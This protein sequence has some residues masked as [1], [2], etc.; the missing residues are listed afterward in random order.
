MLPVMSKNDRLPQ[1]ER[2]YRQLMLEL[3]GRDHPPEWWEGYRRQRRQRLR[4]LI[5]RLVSGAYFP[6]VP[7]SPL[8]FSDWE[9]E[10]FEEAFIQCYWL[11]ALGLPLSG[12]LEGDLP[13]FLCR[14]GQ[15]GWLISLNAERWAQNQAERP[16]G[17]P[18]WAQGTWD[19]WR[20]REWGP[21]PALVQGM[22]HGAFR[23]G[24]GKGKG[25][26]QVPMIWS[27]THAW[28]IVDKLSE[29]WKLESR[30]GSLLNAQGL[31]CPN[32]LEMRIMEWPAPVHSLDLG[33]Y[34]LSFVKD[35]GARRQGN[36]SGGRWKPELQPRV[37]S[38][39]IADIR[40]WPYRRWLAL[41]A[42]SL[43]QVLGPRIAY[44]QS[45]YARRVPGSWTKIQEAIQ[46][47]ILQW[48]RAKYRG[49]APL[50]RKKA[51]LLM[52]SLNLEEVF[53]RSTRRAYRDLARQG[54]LGKYETEWT[55]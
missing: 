12:R 41:D 45:Q 38:Q 2:V 11:K 33:D 22:A 52:G 50:S 35:F 40:H 10:E 6:S 25:K 20:S 24:K 30:L 3:P 17:H 1:E 4:L 9:K 19:R 21:P 7:I 14:L 32:P 49:Q 18:P 55:E 8:R 43:F 36:E 23:R 44:W 13:A 46:R 31:P 28:S 29:A 54:I 47:K 15:S 27:G 34:R 42:E 48:V 37:L 51:H 16:S 5:R 53:R 39:K 26:L